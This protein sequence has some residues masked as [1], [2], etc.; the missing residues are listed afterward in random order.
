MIYVASDLHG[1]SLEK[2][3]AFLEKI[4]FTKDDF[5]YVLGDV[6]DRG[7]DGIKILRWLMSMSNA[8]LLLGNHEAMMLSCDF[9]FDEITEESIDSLTGTKLRQY[10]V[11]VSNSG[12]VTLDTLSGMRDSEIKYILEYLREAPLYEAV[13]AGGRDFLLVHGGLGNFRPDKKLSEYTEMEIVWERPH[14]FQRYFD[15]ITVVLGHTP[16]VAFGEQYRGRALRTETWIDIDVGA[17]IG[18]NPMILRLDDMKD[19]R[20]MVLAE[21]VE[22]TPYILIRPLGGPGA[23]LSKYFKR[24]SIV[25]QIAQWARLRSMLPPDKQYLLIDK[26]EIFGGKENE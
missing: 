21:K 20:Q 3:K 6:I 23:S 4:G 10:S 9:L 2:F 25:S 26:D 8:Q 1:F 11:W 5:L 17:G 15:D 13:T 19:R 14:F 18:L 24:E 12:Q 7:K 22:G 16:T